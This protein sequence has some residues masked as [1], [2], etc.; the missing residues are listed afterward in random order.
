MNNRGPKGP[1]PVLV[2]LR[3]F[4]VSNFVQTASVNG[5]RLRSYGGNDNKE[6][7]G[8]RRLPMSKADQF[9]QYA[10]EAMRWARQAK[11]EKEKQAYIDLARTWT[12]A[13]VQSEYIFGVDDGP[14]EI[15]AP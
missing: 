5:R 11:T 6:S 2:A 1:A 12:Q 15:R 3:P 7:R 4:R 9:Q 13:V 8:V 10:E 14:P